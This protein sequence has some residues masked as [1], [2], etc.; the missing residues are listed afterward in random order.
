MD[1]TKVVD[2]IFGQITGVRFDMKLW[3][4]RVYKYGKGKKVA[5]RLIIDD[6]QTAKRLLTQGALGFGESYMAGSLRIEG[7]LDA[8]LRLRHQFKTIKVS[9]RMAVATM[10][11]KQT[12]PKSRQDQIAYHY[13]LGNDFFKLIL[14]RPTMS[15]SAARYIKATDSL[16]TAQQNKLKLIAEW[17]NLPEESKILDLG[18]GWGGFADYAARQHGWDI[19]GYSLSQAQ[20]TYAKNIIKQHKLDSLVSL[21]YRDMTADFGKASYDAVTIIEAIEHVGQKRLASYFKQLV[22][23]IK[24]GGSLY[25]Q[26]TGQYKHRSVD[27]W[28]LKYVFPGGYLPSLGELITA[29]GEAGFIVEQLRDDTPDYI[30]TMSEWIDNLERHRSEIENMF[31]EPFYR[32]WELWMYGARVAFEVNYMNLFRIHFRKPN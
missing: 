23:V 28:I 4:G 17:L 10:L 20:T 14:D 18:F 24:P 13:D 8:Y 11:A 25:L 6:V 30:S 16:A 12:I 32:L 1:Y 27:K 2:E 15:Y 29:A 3:N 9:P 26:T 22:Q 5:F 7:S 19:T 31:D 21:E